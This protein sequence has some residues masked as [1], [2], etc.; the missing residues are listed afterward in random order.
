MS[1]KKDAT[2]ETTPKKRKTV[3]E[4]KDELAVLRMEFWEIQIQYKKKLISLTKKI[5]KKVLG[6]EK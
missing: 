2:E 3:E 1:K 4:L 5:N 6:G